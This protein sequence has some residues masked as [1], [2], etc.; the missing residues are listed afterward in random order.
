MLNEKQAQAIV[1]ALLS[2]NAAREFD[3][4][5]GLFN[6]LKDPMFSEWRMNYGKLY[7][8]CGRIWYG[9]SSRGWKEGRAVERTANRLLAEVIAREGLDLRVPGGYG[10]EA[11][12]LTAEAAEAVWQA[13]SLDTKLDDKRKDT[14]VAKLTSL[15]DEEIYVPTR[16]RQ[17]G[18]TF[19]NDGF[20]FLLRSNS[21]DWRRRSYVSAEKALRTLFAEHCETHNL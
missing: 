5:C 15:T 10:S 9:T 1:D 11:K 17:E 4:R 20:S 6:A 12:P 19:L 14:F 3:V 18:L 13:L 16:N 21:S 2:C 7:I 8:N